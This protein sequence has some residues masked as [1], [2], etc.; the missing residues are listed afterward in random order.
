MVKITDRA[1]W[2]DMCNEAVRVGREIT[3]GQEPFKLTIGWPGTYG[4]LLVGA[5]S[6]KTPESGLLARALDNGRVMLA[7]EAGSGKTWLLARLIDVAVR[8]FNALPALV[9]LRNLTTDSRPGQA[10]TQEPMIRRLLD[11][12]V[13]SLT[14][15]VTTTGPVPRVVLL[16]DGLNEIPRGDVAEIISAMDEI[17]RRYP[18]ISIIVTDRLVRRAIDLDRWNLATILPLDET[19]VR[20]VWQESDPNRS[21]PTSPA[22]LNRPFFLGAALTTDVASPTQA[23]IIEAYFRK[24][25]GLTSAALTALADVAF[26]AYSRFRAAT[27]P[28][29]W[30]RKRINTDVYKH[31]TDSGALRQGSGYVRF[32]HHLYHDFLAALS[33]SRREE[34]WYREAFEVVT[35]NAASF[36]ALPLAVCELRETSKA[37]LLIRHIYDWNY[38]GASYALV[39]G[40]VSQEMHTAILAML[41]DKRWDII[42]ATATQVTDAL[43]HDDSLL[44]RQLQQ[45]QRREDLFPLLRSIDS[46][47][48]WFTDWVTLF[49][50]PDGSIADEDLVDKLRS[51]DSLESW[52]LANVLRRCDLSEAGRSHLFS[53]ATDPSAV[54]RW[55]MVHV[56]GTH[57]SR[58]AAALAGSLLRDVDGSVRYGAIRASVEMAALTTQPALRTHIL[59]TVL[60][61]VEQNELDRSMRR[62][63]IRSLDVVPPPGDWA[64]ATTSL[65]QQLIGQTRTPEEQGAL[66]RLMTSIA[67]QIG[68]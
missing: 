37:D 33:L 59:S 44:S 41:A 56:L 40:L 36:D 34:Q 62:E 60:E 27:M 19:E 2:S 4:R 48:E 10:D 50:I 28:T 12:S 45:A 5:D 1:P 23:A 9:Q 61:L 18:F 14:R 13:P 46:T 43:R 15:V 58:Q 24:D 64:D 22:A 66:E 39:P 54:V 21:L 30:L 42:K 16:V 65:I 55:R 63:L 49:T 52:T 7:A 6:E 11:N 53:I 26:E 32:A 67:S 17:G 38:Y 25:V 35:L 20:R 57:P 31:L 8:S 51:L 47:Q 29:D 68:G 3:A